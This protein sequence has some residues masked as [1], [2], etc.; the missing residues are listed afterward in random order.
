MFVYEHQ[1]GTA[2]AIALHNHYSHSMKTNMEDRQRYRIKDSHRN[3]AFVGIVKRDPHTYAWTWSGHIDFEDGQEITFTS[4]RSFTTHV[5]AEEYM[6]QFARA[7]I[8]SRLRG[9]Q[10]F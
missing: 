6:R 4:Q 8:D 5:E 9:M 2:F 3:Q 1:P 10:Q 7:R